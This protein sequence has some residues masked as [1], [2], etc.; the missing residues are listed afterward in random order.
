MAWTIEFSAAGQKAL[1]KLSVRDIARI[2]DFLENR[3]ATH[4]SPRDLAT[5]MVGRTDQWRFRVGDYRIIARFE[6]NTLVIIVIDV[7]HRSSI[8]QR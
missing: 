2:V 4:P 7:G 1:D 8:Y 5:R 3:V 6:D